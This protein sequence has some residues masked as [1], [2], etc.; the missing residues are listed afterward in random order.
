MLRRAQSRFRAAALQ[1]LFEGLARVGNLHPHAA[2]ARHGLEKLSD[3]SYGPDPVHRL[4]VY[5]PV[6]R[7]GLLPA[8]LYVHGGGFRILSKETHWLMALAFA[9]QGYVVFSIDYRMVPHRFPAAIEDACRASIWLKKNA[10]AFGADPERMIVSG[11]SAGGNLACGLTVA[12]CY[13]RPE[14]YAKAVRNADVRFAASIP[15]CGFLQV[16]RPERLISSYPGL[17][18]WE[19]D[20]IRHCSRGYL[21]RRLAP[22]AHNAMA[23][24][25]RVIEEE[26]PARPL[27]PTF[28]YCGT[29]D[30]LVDDTRRLEIALNRRRADVTARYYPG[31]LHAFHALIWQ[32]RAKQA[33]RDQLTWLIRQ[34]PPT[35]L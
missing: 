26:A 32:D 31:G 9:R 15:A 4:D 11:E 35:P 19:L 23:D 3:V 17:T 12:S 16:S 2:P 14:P 8:L 24:P 21:G 18:K 25:V 27:P 7:D 5:R 28:A 33:W 22:A 10:A 30:P 34:V 29:R 1:G 20:Y 6:A 13:D